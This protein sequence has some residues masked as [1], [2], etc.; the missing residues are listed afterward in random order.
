MIDKNVAQL[1]KGGHPVKKS[2]SYEHFPYR[3]GRGGGSTPNHPTEKVPPK[4]SVDLERRAKGLVHR[5]AT[6]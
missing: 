6:F 2:Q 5:F 3:Q 4:V 1:L